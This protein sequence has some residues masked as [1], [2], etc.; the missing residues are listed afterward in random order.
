VCGDIFRP[1]FREGSFDGLWNLGVMEHFHAP[2]IERIFA[3]TSRTL[4]PDGRCLIFWPPKY[5]LSV[6]VLTSFLRIADAIRRT[7]LH[8]YPDEVSLFSTIDWARNLL[9]PANLEV[10]R[11]H[12]GI[13]DLFTYVVLIARR[14]GVAS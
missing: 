4:R 5:G 6:L 8:L 14:R 12:F 10:E 13:R 2:E 11:T 9:G 1:P 3:A 7:P